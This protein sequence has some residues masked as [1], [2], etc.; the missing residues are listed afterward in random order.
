MQ[1]YDLWL[2]NSLQIRSLHI[3]LC[4]QVDD[5]PKSVIE[6][7][8]KSVCPKRPFLFGSTRLSYSP[9]C[10]IDVHTCKDICGRKCQ[11]L[12]KNQ[13]PECARG[14]LSPSFLYCQFSPDV[15]VV[16]TTLPFT[17]YEIVEETN[18]KEGKKPYKRY[19]FRE[20][21]KMIFNYFLQDW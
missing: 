21:K 16:N 20:Q 4:F 14:V 12:C 17:T 11:N 15:P 3:F 9:S 13:H 8:K 10:V 1:H 5:A 6:V 19:C 2:L 18:V 7:A